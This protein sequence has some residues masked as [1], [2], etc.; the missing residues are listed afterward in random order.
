MHGMMASYSGALAEITA[1]SKTSHWIWYVWPAHTKVRTTSK[2]REYSLPHASAAL[3]WLQHPT[4]G[5]RLLEITSA[6]NYH[7]SKGVAP[8]TL[9][10]S[11]VDVTKFHECMTMFALAAEHL[12][13]SA[14][15]ESMAAVATL[16]RRALTLLKADDHPT[17]ARVMSSELKELAS[18]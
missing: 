5:P 14:P 8:K 12:N 1:G 16:C 2:D 17:V 4:L 7:L 13:A 10:G 6:A 18:T 11:G 9:F 3:A 15:D